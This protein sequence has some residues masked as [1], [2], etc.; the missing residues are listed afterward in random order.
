MSDTFSRLYQAPTRRLTIQDSSLMKRLLSFAVAALAFVAL[1]AC[2]SDRATGPAG[3]E[4]FARYV[5]IGTS[6]SM[7]VQSDGAVYFSQQQD[8]T[9]LLAHQ[10]FASYSQ[11]LIRAPGCFSP[12]M[13]PLALNIRATGISAGADQTISIPDTTS[14]PL[15]AS[16]PP[17]ND[18]GIDGANTYDALYVTP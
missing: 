18:V 10:A 16:N 11:P 5:A 8:W 17:T 13:A 15:G 9:Q 1:T 7:G 6:L 14:L 12:L 4:A 2:S 3:Q